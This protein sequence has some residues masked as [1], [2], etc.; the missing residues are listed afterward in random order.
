MRPAERKKLLVS[1]ARLSSL[2][3]DASKIK[4]EREK[5]RVRGTTWRPTCG[6]LIRNTCCSIR[7]AASGS[8]VWKPGRRYSHVGADPSEDP[9]FSPDGNR[10][11][12]GGNTTVVEPFSQDGKQLTSDTDDN[13]LNT[14]ST[15]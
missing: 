7:R 14:K 8:T 12:Y 4:N 10:I 11:A 5:E 15:G 1:E 6:R 13:I 3:P 9:K 2:A